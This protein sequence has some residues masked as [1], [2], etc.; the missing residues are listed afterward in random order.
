MSCSLTNLSAAA[1]CLSGTRSR[2]P[3]LRRTFSTAS[4]HLSADGSSSTSSATYRSSDS[5]SWSAL[6]MIRRISCSARGSAEPAWRTRSS[7]SRAA[8]RWDRAAT[9]VASVSAKCGLPASSWPSSRVAS[10]IRCSRSSQNASP[11]SGMSNPSAEIL[12][13]YVARRIDASLLAFC[14]VE[15]CSCSGARSPVDVAIRPS[16]WL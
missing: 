16:R 10:S 1:K 3:A 12:C 7:S 2:S 8:S 4:R 13:S 14:A 11:S 9:S 15:S 6:A 5:S